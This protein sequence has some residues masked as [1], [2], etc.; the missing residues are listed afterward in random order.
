MLFTS[1][2]KT[3]REIWNRLFLC[4]F[5]SWKGVKYKIITNVECVKAFVK[6]PLL[7]SWLFETSDNSNQKPFHFFPLHLVNAI[8]RNKLYFYEG[9]KK[10][11]NSLFVFHNSNAVAPPTSVLYGWTSM[12]WCYFRRIIIYMKKLL[13]SDWLRA[14]QFKCKTSAKK[15]NTSAKSVTPVQITHRN[16]RSWLTERQKEIF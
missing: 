1:G 12:L 10:I 2:M 11:G 7:E 5:C 15:C 14:V 13:D 8:S 4:L 3:K 16:P 6:Y 9:S